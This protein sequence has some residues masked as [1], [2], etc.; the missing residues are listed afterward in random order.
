MSTI[1]NLP[2]GPKGKPLLGNLLESRE[3]PLDFLSLLARDYGDVARF[4]LG[5]KTIVQVNHPDLIRDILVVHPEY[6]HKTGVSRGE[7]GPRKWFSNSRWRPPSPSKAFNATLPLSTAN[8]E[9]RQGFCRDD[10]AFLRSMETE[11]P[12]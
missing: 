5:G 11:H 4:R 8:P 9:V 10:P 7:A 1:E 3:N 6:Y 2:P 12:L